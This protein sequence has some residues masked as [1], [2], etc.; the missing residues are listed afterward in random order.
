MKLVT[1][2]VTSPK[3]RRVEWTSHLK[4]T[5]SSHYTSMEP[6]IKLKTVVEEYSSVIFWRNLVIV[7]FK[8]TT[9]EKYTGWIDVYP[10]G[11][12]SSGT[13]SGTGA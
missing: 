3:N 8:V 10:V 11:V 9:G 2:L 7:G 13:P 12:T 1:W 6:R 4:G 5:L